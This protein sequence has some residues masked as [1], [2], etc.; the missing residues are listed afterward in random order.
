M[1]YVLVPHSH[2]HMKGFTIPEGIQTP[3]EIAHY[4]VQ[5]FKEVVQT[6]LATGIAHPFDPC[7]FNEEEHRIFFKSISDEDF[8]ACFALAKHIGCK[9]HFGSDTH[10]IEKLIRVEEEPYVIQKLGLTF[11]F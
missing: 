10:S 7:R 8:M 4:A 11:V 1:D 5:T 9:F 6:N 2:F 3:S